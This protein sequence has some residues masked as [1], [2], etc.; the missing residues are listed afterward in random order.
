[1]GSY[2]TGVSIANADWIMTHPKPSYGSI[3]LRQLHDLC[4]INS[5]L[6]AKYVNMHI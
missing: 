3:R 2:D 6:G 1:M 5:L 4:P